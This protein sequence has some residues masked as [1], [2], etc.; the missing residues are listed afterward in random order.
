MFIWCRFFY[1][2]FLFV[3]KTM[4]IFWMLLALLVLIL[5][6]SLFDYFTSKQ[7]HF[8]TKFS[9]VFLN[10]QLRFQSS[11]D[12]KQLHSTKPELRFCAGS[13]PAWSVFEIR[14]GEDFWHWS[15]LEIRLNTFCRSTIPQNQFINSSVVWK[16]VICN[17]VYT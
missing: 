14:N 13:S 5:L 17:Y 3:W 6:A 15:C 8:K 2:G 12:N 16:S 4:R 9:L 11:H 7:N 10:I 1:W